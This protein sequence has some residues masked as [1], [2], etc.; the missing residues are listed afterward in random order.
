[1]DNL[2]DPSPEVK[3]KSLREKLPSAL[4]SFD[5]IKELRDR[6]ARLE[7]TVSALQD[8]ILA[9]QSHLYSKSAASPSE[10]AAEPEPERRP[11]PEADKILDRTMLC[12]ELYKVIMSLDSETRFGLIPTGALGEK[13]DRPR[14]WL[15]P[16][17]S[18]LYFDNWGRICAG[19]KN[20]K[21]RG[22]GSYAL[23][24][25]LYEMRE[26]LQSPFIEAALL[27]SF[28]NG[29]IIDPAKKPK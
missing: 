9:V 15:Q 12:A 7:G 3:A 5:E 21:G 19:T 13:K 24:Q 6:I 4:S 18:Y 2:S 25:R 11:L 28:E 8:Q 1:M 26:A 29:F 17:N 22:N 16:G 10:D 23:L 14:I 27:K 20:P